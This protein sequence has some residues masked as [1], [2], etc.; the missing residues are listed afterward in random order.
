MKLYKSFLLFLQNLDFKIKLKLKNYQV[1]C[2]IVCSLK[3]FN[4]EVKEMEGGEER[5]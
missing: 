4:Y 3:N 1:L 2:K 5:N